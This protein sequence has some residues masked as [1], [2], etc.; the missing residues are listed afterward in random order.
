MEEMS[1]IKVF[2]RPNLEKRERTKSEYEFKDW[3]GPDGSGALGTAMSNRAIHF[4][5]TRTTSTEKTAQHQRD[6]ISSLASAR[7]QCVRSGSRF[8]KNSVDL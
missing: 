1:S 3:R 7:L 2:S 4:H 5:S 8:L 6:R